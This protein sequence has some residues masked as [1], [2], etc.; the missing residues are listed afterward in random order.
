M[1]EAL[2]M[3][4]LALTLTLTLS[5]SAQ[6][7]TNGDPAGSCCR[8]SRSFSN[9]G[10]ISVDLGAPGENIRSTWRTSQES[11]HFATG[12]SQSTPFVAGA[13]ALLMG[14]CK[15]AKR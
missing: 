10:R 14:A 2:T 6:R 4:A 7:P 8:F 12:T 3:Y 11:Y 9:Y 1:P 13:V 15:D 5:L